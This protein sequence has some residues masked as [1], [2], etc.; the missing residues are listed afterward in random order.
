MVRKRQDKENWGPKKSKAPGRSTD[1][2]S[3]LGGMWQWAGES[4]TN[5]KCGERQER[6][7]GCVPSKNRH[8]V[9]QQWES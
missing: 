3:V 8:P 6:D 7:L 2:E 1:A 9:E 5:C 4:I